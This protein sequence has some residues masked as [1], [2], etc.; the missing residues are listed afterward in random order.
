MANT[1]E[2]KEVPDSTVSPTTPHLCRNEKVPSVPA[3]L[4]HLA[5]PPDRMSRRTLMSRG[6]ILFLGAYAPHNLVGA[7]TEP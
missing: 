5:A 3:E 1:M 7:G 2:I 6:G 4:E